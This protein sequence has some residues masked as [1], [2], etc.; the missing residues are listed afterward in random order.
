[1]T[2]LVWAMTKGGPLNSTETVG[3]YVYFAAF[4][5]KQWGYATAGAVSLFAIMAVVAVV[6]RRVS[7]RE[8]VEY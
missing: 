1:M 2:R 4:Q 3:I 7:R 8:V 6:V 5:A